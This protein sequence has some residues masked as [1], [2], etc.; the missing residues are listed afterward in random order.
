MISQ[1]LYL[2]KEKLKFRN[3]SIKIFYEG[4]RLVDNL[5][6]DKFNDSVNEYY[7]LD[8]T[9]IHPSLKN[10]PMEFVYQKKSYNDNTKQFE[11]DRNFQKGREM[12]TGYSDHFPI[13]C[14]IDLIESDIN[15]EYGK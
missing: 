4:L 1:G 11:D 6:P 8:K 5:S 13:M 10:N 15:I 9:K 14:I 12:N 7:Y 2:G 3:N